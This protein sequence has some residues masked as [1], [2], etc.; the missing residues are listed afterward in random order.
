MNKGKLYVP[1]GSKLYVAAV[2]LAFAYVVGR[3][4][5]SFVATDTY[6]QGFNYS[7]YVGII[8][9]VAELCIPIGFILAQKNLK[10]TVIGNIALIVYL[11]INL[12]DASYILLHGIDGADN[13]LGWLLIA[14]LLAAVVIAKNIVPLIC[15]TI[16]F[17][18]ILISSRNRLVFT[19]ITSL[20]MFFYTLTTSFLFLSH[21]YLMLEDY[22]NQTNTHLLFISF[23]IGSV[24]LLTAA[25]ICF[26]LS[27]KNEELPPEQQPMVYGQSAPTQQVQTV[28]QEPAESTND[29][30]T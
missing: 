26:S 4:V 14:P 22:I 9:L 2:I 15:N 18:F 20:S 16:S 19:L 29:V 25:Y 3:A 11:I 27:L 21:R 12:I 13:N 23:Y 1:K 30:N 28:Q 7:F 10:L 24:L 8:M 17:I 5:I 6:I